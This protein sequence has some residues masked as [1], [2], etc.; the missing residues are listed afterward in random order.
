M[1]HYTIGGMSFACAAIA[2]AF[3]L[4]TMLALRR[5]NRKARPLWSQPRT[6]IRLAA[7]AGL[8]FVVGS[9]VAPRGGAAAAEP[10]MVPMPPSGTRRLF[11]ASEL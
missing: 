11:P 9:L 7:C 3:W 5:G 8:G 4:V 10:T 6:W 1:N 2:P